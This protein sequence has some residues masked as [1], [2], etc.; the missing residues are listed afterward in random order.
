MFQY[1]PRILPY[2]RPYWHLGVL[3]VVL[4]V[5]AG[6]ADLLGPWPLKILVDNALGDYPAPGWLQAI[7]GQ[8]GTKTSLLVLAVSAGLV[9]ALVRNALSVADNYVQTKLEQ[10]MILDFRSDLFNH[11]QR[12]SL[13]FHDQR[14]SGMLIYAINSQGDAVAGM[15]MII[16]ALAQSLI[17]LVGM[18]WIVFWIDRWLALLSMAV[19]PFLAYSVQYY[20]TRIQGRL[21]HVCTMEAVAVH[22][23]RGDVHAAGDCRIRART[24]RILPVPRPGERS[25]GARAVT[26][27]RRC[28]RWR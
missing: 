20:A 4:I 17:T 23:S 1:F 9:V 18:F 13:A 8:A 22:R 7:V 26:V 19:A 24:V 2:L 15:I 3:L 16:P 28:S 27:R 21:A 12:L 6:A 14:R 5:L 11:A 25:G 10:R